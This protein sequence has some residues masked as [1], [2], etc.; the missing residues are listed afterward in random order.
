[1]KKWAGILFVWWYVVAPATTVRQPDGRV[2]SWP[3]ALEG[4][5]IEEAQCR[6]RAEA[7]SNTYRV[8]AYC[9][10]SEVLRELRGVR[11]R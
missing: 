8:P 9:E 2:V 3:A 6:R 11:V 10:P 7:I 1:M 4:P 5:Y